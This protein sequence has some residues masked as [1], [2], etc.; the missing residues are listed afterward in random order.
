M[1]FRVKNFT[2]D[3][4]FD[5]DP[6]FIFDQ[7]DYQLFAEYVCATSVHLIV[8]RLDMD[9]IPEGLQL[10]IL[11]HDISQ[12]LSVPSSTGH[13]ICIPYTCELSLIHI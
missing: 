5:H 1:T 6:P 2:V 3:L 7:T 4:Y 10:L 12:I 9:F 8:R 13:E 11:Y